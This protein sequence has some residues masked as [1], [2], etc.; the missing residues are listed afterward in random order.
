MKRIA[1]LMMAG[2][3]LAACQTNA[4]PETAPSV[5]ASPRAAVHAPLP[6]VE[7]SRQDANRDDVIQS[8]AQRKIRTL[9]P[10]SYRA[11]TV[12]VWNGSVLLMGAVIKPEQRRRAEQNA[13]S[14]SGAKA[15]INELVLAEDRALDLFLPNTAMEAKVRQSLGIE[16]KSGLIVRVLNNVAFLLGGVTDKAQAQTLREDAG[17]V[18]GIKWVVAHLTATP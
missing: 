16:G 17:E 3:A 6:M 9:D 7:R 11:V 4:D 10:S 2:F 1:A 5:A 12:E 14:I 8:M 15:V 18:D 13:A